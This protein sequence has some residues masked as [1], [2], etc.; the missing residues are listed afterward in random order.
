MYIKLENNVNNWKRI[1]LYRYYLLDNL[2]LNK[3]IFK[4]TRTKCI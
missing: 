3:K 2:L 1:L 4:F